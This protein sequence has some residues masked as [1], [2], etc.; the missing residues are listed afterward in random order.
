[1]NVKEIVRQ[2]LKTG[3]LSL[4]QETCLYELF[5]ANCPDE[6]DLRAADALI[7]ALL[8]GAVQRESHNW[9]PCASMPDFAA[10]PLKIDEQRTKE[11]PFRDP[12]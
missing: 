10:F 5:E 4:F 7:N 11:Y 8:D 2:A 3:R 1:M 9:D 6:E 12:L